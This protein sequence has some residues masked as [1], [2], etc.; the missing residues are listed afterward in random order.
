MKLYSSVVTLFTW[1]N[2]KLLGR[3]KSGFKRSFNWNKYQSKL[4]AQ[5][6]NWYLDF[7]IDPKFI[8]MV[9][10]KDY[11]VI[12]VGRNFAIKQSKMI[13]DHMITFD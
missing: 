10:I 3:L 9:E 5:V 6:Q 11:K 12:I 4:A 2:A 1:G 13:W 8:P 7:L